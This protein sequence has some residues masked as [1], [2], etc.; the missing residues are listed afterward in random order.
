MRYAAIIFFALFLLFAF[1]QINDPDPV[2]WVALYLV[3]AYISYRAF[4]NK[5]NTE[6]LT[7]L[8]ALYLAIAF[9]SLLAMTAYEGFFT[10]G[11]GMEMK[12]NNQELVR[13]ASGI[14]ICVFVFVIYL[15]YAS[16]RN[17]PISGSANVS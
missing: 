10:E 1:V 5:Y 15:I 9:N 8:I 3:P 12:T 7:T 4:L 11:A 6:V 13:E 16:R 2:L 17:Y 14:F